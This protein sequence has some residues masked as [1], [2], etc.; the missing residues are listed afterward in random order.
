M[1]PRGIGL[2]VVVGALACA[3]E[4][5]GTHLYRLQPPAAPLGSEAAPCEPEARGSLLVRDLQ[6]AAEYDDVRMAYRESEYQL[7]RYEYHEW[8]A[9][10]GEL[11]SDALRD[12]YAASAWF[13]RV[14]REQDA[15]VAAVLHGRVLALEEVDLDATRWVAHLRLELEL[16]DAKTHAPL[17]SHEYDATRPLEERS[18]NGLAAATS[19]ILREVID[20]SGREM[21]TVISGSCERGGDAAEPGPRS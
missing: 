6:V 15:S 19:A 9:P 21:A 13:S 5:P 16:L 14:E 8:A 10:P 12:G 3:P 18:P 7:Q 11:V 2:A 1:R 17:W 20:A 4:V